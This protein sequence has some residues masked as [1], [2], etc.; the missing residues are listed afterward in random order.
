VGLHLL[1]HCGV[2]N[3]FAVL[4]RGVCPNEIVVQHNQWSMTLTLRDK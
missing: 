4:K 1:M 2:P 3:V